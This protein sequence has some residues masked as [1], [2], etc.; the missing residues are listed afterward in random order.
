MEPLP[1]PKAPRLVSCA[2]FPFSPP[3][4]Q[5]SPYVSPTAIPPALHTS[6]TTHLPHPSP[7][8]HPLQPSQPPPTPG[9]AV[10]W[11]VTGNPPSICTSAQNTPPLPAAFSV[12]A[13]LLS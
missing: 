5:K 10:L 8:P 3:V 13:F 6:I 12:E 2:S 11:T 4:H 9:P 1:T 7:S